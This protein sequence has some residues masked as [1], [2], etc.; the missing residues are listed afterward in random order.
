MPRPAFCQICRMAHVA[1]AA[2]P[3]HACHVRSN[4]NFSIKQLIESIPS[5]VYR[6]QLELLLGDPPVY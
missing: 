4:A 3:T 1:L 2:C 6:I 5:K